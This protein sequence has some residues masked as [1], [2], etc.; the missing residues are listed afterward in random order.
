MYPNSESGDGGLRG[1]AVFLALGLAVLLCG[2]LVGFSE[3]TDTYKHEVR[4]VAA[5]GEQVRTVDSVLTSDDITVDEQAVLLETITSDS[6]V[7]KSEPVGLQFRYPDG[8][9]GTEY[10][11]EF[12]DAYYVLETATE[13]RPHL[14]VATG[15]RVSFAVAGLL[16][17]VAG[18]VPILRTVLAPNVVF[19]R[20]LKRLL[21]ICLPVW[22]LLILVPAVVLGLVFPLVF[23]TVVEL[24]LS[25][26]V[27]PF[28]L[29]TGICATGT[30]LAL[31]A[32]DLSDTFFLASAVNA[33]IVWMTLVAADV[34]PGGGQAR[35]TLTLLLGVSGFSVLIGQVL[36]WYILRWREL[37]QREKPPSPTYWR[38]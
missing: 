29:A 20:P 19:T 30:A 37:R 24:P 36:G 8:T 4:E 12:D 11:I 15:A 25:L 14:V 16:L 26:F 22:A 32:T 27:T 34:A 2:A 10:L 31:R 35:A 23:E 18:G 3:W 5:D 38:I 33:P 1:A 21:G 9:E 28:L 13:Q 7:Y 17:V 6:P